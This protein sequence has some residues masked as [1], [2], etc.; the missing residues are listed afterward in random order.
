VGSGLGF[1]GYSAQTDVTALSELVAS[2]EEEQE[3]QA[4]KDPTDKIKKINQQLAHI[5]DYNTDVNQQLGKIRKTLQ[6]NSLQTVV[7]N[8][9]DQNE[10]AQKAIEELFTKFDA[11]EKSR[12]KSKTVKKTRQTK[13]VAPP[14]KWVVNLISFKQL[15]YAKRKSTEFEKKGIPVK[16]TTAKIDGVKWYRL[17]TKG[18]KRKSSAQ[19]YA[20]KVKKTLNLTSVWVTK[21]K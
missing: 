6:T 7:D 20:N 17:T 1:I 10:Q 2:L 19:T 14:V 13:K 12:F 18:F 11:L 21:D 15:W 9:N 5:K 4:A 8:L 16:I 3:L